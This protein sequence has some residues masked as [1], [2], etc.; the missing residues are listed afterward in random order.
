M[1]SLINYKLKF[2]NE[3]FQVTE[4]S[5]MPTLFAKKF[6]SFT[7]LWVQKSGFTTFDVLGHVKNV[8]GWLAELSRVLK[9][10]G[11]LAMFSESKLGKH[12]YIRNYLMRRGINTDPHAEFHISL[13]SKEELQ[14]KLR[15]AGF[16][17]K[18]MFSFVSGM[19]SNNS[20]SV[21]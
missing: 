16:A 21:R 7:Y 5:L 12:A 4:V 1:A 8:D 14:E 2:I 3:D 18:R 11:A 10:G 19:V 20:E 9:P 6:C 17:V 13:Y 15:I